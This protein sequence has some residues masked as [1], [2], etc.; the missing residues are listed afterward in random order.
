MAEILTI[1]AEDDMPTAPKVFKQT[2]S[3]PEDTPTPELYFPTGGSTTMKAVE[4]DTPEL[5]S[6][7]CPSPSGTI[8]KT[9]TMARM[10]SFLGSSLT[11][12]LASPATAVQ[13]ERKPLF[14]ESSD[15]SNSESSGQQDSDSST[16]KPAAL[17]LDGP[18]QA[19]QPA[20]KGDKPMVGKSEPAATQ[21]QQQ[22]QKKTPGQQQAD[23]ARRLLKQDKKANDQLPT[24]PASAGPYG[25]AQ[26]NY[27]MDTWNF[28]FQP[29]GFQ[30]YTQPVSGCLPYTAVTGLPMD[31][32]GSTVYQQPGAG[33]YMMNM[34]QPVPYPGY[35]QPQMAQQMAQMQY[36]YSGGYLGPFEM[37]AEPYYGPQMAYPQAAYPQTAYPQT[38]FP[39]MAFPQMAYPQTAFPQADFPLTAFPQTTFPQPAFSEQ[40]YIYG[41]AFAA[42]QPH[43]LF[44]NEPAIV[45]QTMSL[46]PVASLA[47]QPASPP[48]RRRLSFTDMVASPNKVRDRCLF[49]V[50]I[51]ACVHGMGYTMYGKKK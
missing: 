18:Q 4:A 20:V 21:K 35:Y 11:D 32:F 42:Q 48:G 50:R 15:S 46:S 7:S 16:F 51:H 12:L 47:Y 13:K 14:Q 39:Q 27:G 28:N 24:V 2:K 38:A 1:R 25:T 22:P 34:G 10:K 45:E 23:V 36:S 6:D 37:P 17:S 29:N 44:Q 43:S 30:P 41:S 5:R 49:N 19:S 40:Q 8:L 3:K 33:P 9:P 31:T 26:G